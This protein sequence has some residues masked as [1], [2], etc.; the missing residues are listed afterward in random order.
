MKI[1]SNVIKKKMMILKIKKKVKKEISI[2]IFIVI[3][4]FFSHIFFCLDMIDTV[5]MV[6]K[7]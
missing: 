2:V 3:N 7:I 6:A 5:S 1:Y 4:Q